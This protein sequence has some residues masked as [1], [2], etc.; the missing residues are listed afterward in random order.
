MAQLVPLGLSAKILY[1]QCATNSPVVQQPN[2]PGRHPK[3]IVS[4]NRYGRDKRVARL[5]AECHD[6]LIS[7]LATQR[8]WVEMLEQSLAERKFDLARMQQQARRK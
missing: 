4:L 5:A 8:Q 1:L 2:R 6:G 3:S 7:K